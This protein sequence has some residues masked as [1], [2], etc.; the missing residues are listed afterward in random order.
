MRKNFR[1]Y[2]NQKYDNSVV[3]VSELQNYLSDHRGLIEYFEGQENFYLFFITRDKIQL[4]SIEK[5]KGLSEQISQFYRATTDLKFITENTSSADSTFILSSTNLHQSLLSPLIINLESPIQQLI[6]V[7]DGILNEL[8]FGIFLTEKIPINGEVDYRSLPYL[9]RKYAISYAYSGT[10]LLSQNS[11][12][13]KTKHL[14][15]GFAPTYNEY[16]KKITSS[17]KT[18]R[19]PIEFVRS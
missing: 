19:D 4:H 15:A 2:Y 12:L 5:S 3:S 10:H 8:N 11:K 1:Q 9:L 7:S 18:R 17:L 16:D 13:K 14:F 6:I